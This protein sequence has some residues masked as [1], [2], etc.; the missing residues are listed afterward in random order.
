MKTLL[1]IKSGYFYGVRLW[2]RFISN[3]YEKIRLVTI[4]TF[5]G[6]GV[7]VGAPAAGA[8]T[9]CKPAISVSNK[10]WSK[11]RRGNGRQGVSGGFFFSAK[12]PGEQIGAHS[13]ALWHPYGDTERL[14]K[15]CIFLFCKTLH[16]LHLIRLQTTTRAQDFCYTVWQRILMFFSECNTFIPLQRNHSNAYIPKCN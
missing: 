13:W 2:S 8:T 11:T 14:R 3:W 16:L 10:T 5:L 15:I 9:T 6:V 4:N 7:T 12:L 1:I